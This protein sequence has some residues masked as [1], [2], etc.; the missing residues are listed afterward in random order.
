MRKM[1][2]VSPSHPAVYESL[3]RVLAS[4]SD[5]EIIYDRRLPDQRKRPRGKSMWSMGPLS[6]L[7]DRRSHQDVDE[8]ILNRGWGVVSLE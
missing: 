2:I 1:F 3:K 4:E 8:Q 7:G 5:V 6:E